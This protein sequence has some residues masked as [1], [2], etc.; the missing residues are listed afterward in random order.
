MP[1]WLIGAVP[2]FCCC[3]LCRSL[4]S[5]GGKLPFYGKAAPRSRE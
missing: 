1:F 3:A 4:W 2:V 5:F